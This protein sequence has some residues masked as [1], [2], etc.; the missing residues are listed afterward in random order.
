M[1]NIQPIIHSC[2]IVTLEQRESNPGLNKI[3]CIIFNLIS[4]QKWIYYSNSSFING[5]IKILDPSPDT[6]ISSLSRF[7]SSR[8]RLEPNFFSVQTKLFIYLFLHLSFLHRLYANRSLKFNYQLNY[9]NWLMTINVINYNHFNK[10]KPHPPHKILKTS[11][12][13]KIQTIMINNNYHILQTKKNLITCTMYLHL[14]NS[15][16]SL[17]YLFNLSFSPSFP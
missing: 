1:V 8:I 5:F 14:R 13:R 6:Y 12:Q 11:Y 17:K 3:F 2:A 15:T 10:M 9:Q 4:Y 7:D 16:F